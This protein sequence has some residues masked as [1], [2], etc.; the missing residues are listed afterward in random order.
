MTEL[1]IKLAIKKADEST[2]SF[3]SEDQNNSVNN[4]W[5]YN[6]IPDCCHRN[7]VL[8]MLPPDLSMRTPCYCFI[9][10]GLPIIYLSFFNTKIC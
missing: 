9:L 6:I 8:F 2:I 10:L 1:D 4:K 5:L 7:Y 3:D